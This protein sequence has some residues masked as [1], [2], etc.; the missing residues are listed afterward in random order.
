MA[1]STPK[2]FNFRSTSGYVTDGSNETYVVLADTYPTSRSVGGE[3]VTFGTQNDLSGTNDFENRDSGI[4]RRLAG[5]MYADGT[6]GGTW[7]F[8]VDLP[9]AGDY[10][11]RVALGDAGT[12]QPSQKLAIYDDSTLKVTIDPAS[13]AIDEW[14]DATEVVL[15]ATTWPT[16]NAQITLTFA[17]TICIFRIGNSDAFTTLAHVEIEPAVAARRFLLVR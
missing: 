11:I 16:T 17:S 2:G 15:N 8:R 4:D 13:V 10:K 9:S 14:S 5:V 7:E 1:W 3:S 12:A 6:D